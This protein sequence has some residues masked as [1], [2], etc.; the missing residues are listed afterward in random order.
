MLSKKELKELI[1][2][3]SYEELKSYYLENS[4]IY[5]KYDY[6]IKDY[7]QKIINIDSNDMINYSSRL[8]DAVMSLNSLK[9][10]MKYYSDILPIIKKEL[11]KKENEKMNN[12]QYEIY[13]NDNKINIEKLINAIEEKKQEFYN[14]PIVQVS[15]DKTIELSKEEI[16]TII[17]QLK[18]E[19]IAIIKDKIGNILEVKKLEFNNN[20]GFDGIIK[21]EK[22]TININTILAGGYNIQ[23]LHYRTLANK[24]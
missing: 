23:K 21:G 17:E 7:A 12:E 2:S 15:K 13:I 4:E 10:D 6:M 20:R 5:N 3:M 22:G 16:D 18:I 9:K 19:T 8:N 14:N 1:I 11:D 24:Y